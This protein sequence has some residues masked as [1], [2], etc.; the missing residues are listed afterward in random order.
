MQLEILRVGTATG[1]QIS[2]RNQRRRT[3]SWLKNLKSDSDA[4]QNSKPGIA[5][6]GIPRPVIK[7]SKS[8]KNCIFEFFDF[9]FRPKLS[10]IHGQFMSAKQILISISKGYNMV[11]TVCYEY[12][13]IDGACNL[14]F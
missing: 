2:G 4:A 1:L 10:L 7:S 8:G 3:K 12:E 11:C 13:Y 5:E 6:L 14:K 9:L